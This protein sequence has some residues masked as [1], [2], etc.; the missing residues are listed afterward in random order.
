MLRKPRLLLVH[1]LS[2]A[3]AAL[4]RLA[5][6]EYRSFQADSGN[7]AFGAAARKA[8]DVVLLNYRLPDMDVDTAV[9]AFLA[10]GPRSA[11]AIVV[12]LDPA[13]ATA[14]QDIL[15][16]GVQQYLVNEGLTPRLVRHA[17]R[18]VLHVVRLE[19]TLAEREAALREREAQLQEANRRLIATVEER[20]TELRRVADALRQVAPEQASVLARDLHSELGSRAA[21]LDHDLDRLKAVVR[22]AATVT[23]DGNQ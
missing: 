15:R 23:Q 18:G 19:R 9:Q 4:I 3:R 20:S 7:T 10:G 11:P 8:P 6:P 21:S 12:L 17:L 13:D 22:Q 16:S 1:P 2:D 5:G 14:G